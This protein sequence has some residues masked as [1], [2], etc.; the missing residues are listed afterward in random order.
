M[1]ALLSSV[2]QVR[3]SAD[4]NE[5][6]KLLEKGWRILDLYFNNERPVYVLGQIGN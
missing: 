6:N 4:I 5:A 1:L 2:K 3:E